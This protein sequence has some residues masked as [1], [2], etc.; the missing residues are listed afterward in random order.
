V[1]PPFVV[2]STMIL[3]TPERVPDAQAIG[4]FSGT[5]TSHLRID[6]IVRSAAETAGSCAR[7]AP[8]GDM[9]VGKGNGKPS[10]DSS[11]TWI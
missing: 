4:F 11:V 10:V 3:V 1:T 8:S 2:T 9:V 7:A 5:R 6:A